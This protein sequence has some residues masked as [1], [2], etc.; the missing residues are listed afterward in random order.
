M[1][2]RAAASDYDDWETVYKNPGWGSKYLIPLLKKVETYQPGGSA[3]HGT[4]GPI[5]VSYM[6]GETNV[7]DQYLAVASQYDKE[8]GFTDDVNDFFNCNRYGELSN[9]T[10][11]E[12]RRVVRVLFENNRAVGVE[13]VG[14]AEGRVKGEV[15]PLKSYASRLVVLSAGAFGSPAILERYSATFLLHLTGSTVILKR[16]GIGA[17]DVLKRNNIPQFVDLPGVGEH[18]MDHNLIFA[19]YIASEDADTLDDLFSGKDEELEPYATRW[20]K[21]GGGLMRHN[22]IDAG[23]KMRPNAEDLREIGP[24]FQPR[25]SAYFANAP[26]KPVAWIGTLAAYAGGNPTVPRGKYFSFGYY[27]EYPFSVGRV[28]ITSGL[29]AYGKLD[30]EPGY[31]DHIYDMGVLRWGYKKSREFARRMDCYRGELKIGHPV[32]PAGSKAKT[33]E[34]AKPVPIDAPDI[35][36]SAED[37]KAIDEFHRGN[38]QT[39]WH[40]IGTCAM[41]PREE[42]GVVDANLN[43]YGTVNLK[44]ADCSIAPANV[45]ANTY[46][47]ALAIGEKAAVIIAKELGISGVSEA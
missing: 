22:G 24:E 3:V 27:T 41:K 37:N 45:S 5:K 21:D 46:N 16:S 42:G 13:H 31:L 29:D 10:T 1:Y 26:D 17:A 7:A 20:E 43:V 8:R 11:V 40:S 23:I 35:E 32:F 12:R 25:W 9:L 33:D 38:V 39:S 4:S 14:D 19:P 28:H 30:F 18:Y 15:V 34:S 44:V 36:Y 47:T 2:T 6:E